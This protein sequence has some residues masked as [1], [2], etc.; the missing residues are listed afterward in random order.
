MVLNGVN[1]A[2]YSRHA[3]RCT[4]VL[5]EPGAPEPFAEIPFPSEFRVGDVHA[6]TVFH[7]DPEEFEYG[8]RMEG[9]FNPRVGHRFDPQRVLLDPAVR[10]GLAI[11]VGTAR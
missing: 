8:Y 3:T 9:P 10:G 7:L 6:M 4:L 11:A 2:V 1:F 5:F